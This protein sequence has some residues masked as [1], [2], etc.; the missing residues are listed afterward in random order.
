MNIADIK[1]EVDGFFTTQNFTT[2]RRR[3]QADLELWRLKPYNAGAGY[4]SYTSNYPRLVA[5]KAMAML[6]Q[7][8]LIIRYPDDTFD[9][10][11]Q[12]KASNMERFLYGCL[13]MMD[14]RIKGTQPTFRDQLKWLLSLRGRVFP[15]VLMNKNAKGETF[16][17][18]ALWDAYST[19]YWL[20]ANDVERACHVRAATKDQIKAE[21]A[22]DIKNAATR[23][24]LPA[25]N[26]LVYDYWD[27]EVNAVFIDGQWLKDPTPHGVGHCPV[28]YIKAGAMP[29]IWQTDDSA[30]ETYEGESIFV[31]LRTVM[32]TIN[33]TVSD[34]SSIVRRGVKTPL[35]VWSSDGQQT[36]G[37]DV[38]QVEKGAEVQLRSD[39]VVKP[40]MEPAMPK[41][42]MPLL[43]FSLGE[44]QRAGFPATSFGELG[45][46]LSG[47]AISQLQESIT[48]VLEPFAKAVETVYDRVCKE[49]LEQYAQGGFKPIEVRGRTSYNR[50]FGYPIAERISSDEID[51]KWIPE[52][53][54]V[55]VLPKDDVQA[56]NLAQLA[57]Q[58]DA[59]GEPLLS[60]QTTHE[61]ILHL[62]DPDLEQDRLAAEWADAQPL[63]RLFKQFQSQLSLGQY[64]EAQLTLVEIQKFMMAMNPGLPPKGGQARGAISPTEELAGQGQGMAPAPTGV[65]P[66]VSPPETMGQVSGGQASAGR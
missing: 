30:L 11:E 44:A 50:P 38:W 8:R 16:P 57:R 34:L 13:T 27:K 10:D 23:T 14:S 52:I 7:A 43:Q 45:F 9:K 12:L 53:K 32:P 66:M 6:G 4:Y 42:A 62:D 39:V 61:E 24:G 2:L 54:L 60:Q 29:S 49:L 21:Y 25:N 31:A 20:N 22:V 18:V 64:R 55:T 48:T 46:R 36:L 26:I 3:W 1:K 19:A 41:D 65:S 58:P 35:G 59:R 51:P 40:L 33:K 28:F 47:F 5:D 17:D 63:Q 37:A 15:R 56:Y